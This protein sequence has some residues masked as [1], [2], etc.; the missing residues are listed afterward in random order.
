VLVCLF[1]FSFEAQDRLIICDD[2]LFFLFPYVTYGSSDFEFLAAEKCTDII[3]ATA[4][5]LIHR[6]PPST[7]FKPSLTVMERS[8]L[9]SDE[10]RRL[11]AAS[12]DLD[13]GPAFWLGLLAV[14]G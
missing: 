13:L 14:L 4:D 1:F 6:N 8:H 2:Y 12:R 5:Q 7:R 3:A 11:L 9:K 10:A